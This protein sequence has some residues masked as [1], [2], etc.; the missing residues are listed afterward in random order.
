MGIARRSRQTTH[1]E[2]T[3]VRGGLGRAAQVLVVALVGDVVAGCLWGWLRPVTRVVVS[4]S[5]GASLD[6]GSADAAFASFAWYVCVVGVVGVA[7]GLWTFLAGRGTRGIPMMVWV[8]LCSVAGAWC[9][10]LFGEAVARHV[11]P[12]GSSPGPG[13]VLALVDAVD[14]GPGLLVAAAGALVAYWL[15][16]LLSTDGAFTRPVRR[17]ASGGVVDDGEETE[18]TITV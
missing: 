15:C 10:L 3:R 16:A 11:H 2:R 6:P 5:Y 18:T 14:A 17:A 7:L 8:T 9:F 13:Q 1:A 4:S 12:E